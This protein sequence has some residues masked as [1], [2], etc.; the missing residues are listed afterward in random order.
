VLLNLASV[1]EVSR[2]VVL[3][4]HDRVIANSQRHGVPDEPTMVDS[5]DA[6]ATLR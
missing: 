3:G 4:L 6:V 2:F 1:G 5:I